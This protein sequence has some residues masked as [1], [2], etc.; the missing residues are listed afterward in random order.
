MGEQ[1]REF[2]PPMPAGPEPEL[3]SPP[4]P[5]YGGWQP[6]AHSSGYAGPP[7]APA[8]PAVQADNGPAVAGFVLSVVSAGLLLL[9][10][11]LSSVLSV[12]SSTLGIVFSRKGKAKV[13]SGETTRHAGL[14][15]AGFVVGIIGL[16][17]SVLATLFW[18]LVLTDEDARRELER[19]FD[20]S[21]SVGAPLRVA[22]AAAR[23]L[24]A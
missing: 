5:A 21:Q 4:A 24:L 2:L 6:P 12:G 3:G 11:G 9:S 7:A 19:E 10:G 15:Q 13:R 16:C 20:E 1:P 17:L 18:I 23:L 14:A 8:A 22:A